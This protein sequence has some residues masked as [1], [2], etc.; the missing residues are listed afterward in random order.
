M[1]TLKNTNLPRHTD[2]PK[3]DGHGWSNSRPGCPQQRVCRDAWN[4]NRQPAQLIELLQATRVAKEVTR[5]PSVSKQV[6][7]SGPEAAREDISTSG[8][9]AMKRMIRFA[10]KTREERGI[11]GLETAQ[12]QPFVFMATDKKPVL[13]LF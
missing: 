5:T 3:G 7:E 6:T 11:T 13:F 8:G 9:V 1:A 10:Q 2:V 4:A 12:K